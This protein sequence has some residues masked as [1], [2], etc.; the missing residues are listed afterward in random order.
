MIDRPSRPIIALIVGG[1]LVVVCYYF[2][3][4]PVARFVHDHPR[5]PAAFVPWATRLSDWTV[6]LLNLGMVAVV[7][8]WLM[9]PGGR[10]Q[11][12]LLA[13]A[14]NLVATTTIK[15]LLKWT[16]G[17]PVPNAWFDRDPTAI[18]RGICGFHLFRFAAGDR[19]FPSGHAAATFA[20]LSILW[21]CR[22]RWR[23]AYALLAGLMCAALIG[24]NYHFVGDVIAGAMLGSITGLYTTRILRL[25]P[26][27][28]REGPD[29]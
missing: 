20:V 5:F 22:P 10:L 29:Q 6:Y 25:R 7:A 15:D 2:V 9:R 11:T 8:W 24:L 17:R 3:D 21:L 23:W 27:D 16:F 18:T 4:G 12:L 19:S 13:I 26:I 14:A 1:I 28:V